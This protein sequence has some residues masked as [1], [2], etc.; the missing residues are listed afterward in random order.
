MEQERGQGL[1][2]QGGDYL[3]EEG[4]KPNVL[5]HFVQLPEADP[6]VSVKKIEAY[7]ET[8]KMSPR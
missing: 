2:V 7:K 8:Q 6:V 3:M 5:Q 1:L 4:P